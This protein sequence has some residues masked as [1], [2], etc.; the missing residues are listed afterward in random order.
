MV[1]VVGADQLRR[2][3]QSLIG[4]SDTPFEHMR[5]AERSSNG[6]DVLGLALPCLAGSIAEGQGLETAIIKAHLTVLSRLPDSLIARKRGSKEAA[7][8]SRRASDV[9]A[10][11]WPGRREGIRLFDAIDRWLRAE[12]HA[13]NPGTT[14]D[15]VTAALFVG[16][17]EGIIRLPIDKAGW[18]A[19]DLG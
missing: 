6:R 4:L 19:A 1:A 11:G 17:R 9:I 2:N 18:E 5:D 10:A 12:G 3:A 14:A 13:R 7:E 16:L 15:L 8:A